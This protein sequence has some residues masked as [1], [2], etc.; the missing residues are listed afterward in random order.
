MTLSCELTM[1]P[2]GAARLRQMAP[3]LILLVIGALLMM[4]GIIYELGE[5]PSGDQHYRPT[6]TSA[7]QSR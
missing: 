7:L 1:E 2:A 3:W 6:L 4:P 5:R